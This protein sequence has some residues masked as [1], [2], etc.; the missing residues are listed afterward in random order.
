MAPQGR[1]LMATLAQ[2]SRTV[3]AETVS[4]RSKRLRE[5]A[6]TAV[7]TLLG[8]V[9]M[10]IFLMPLGYMLATAFKPDA[11][12]SA[13]H[14]PLWPAKAETYNYQNQDLPLYNVPTATGLQQWALVKGYREDSDF[15]D[16]AHPEKGVF[17]WKG[18]YRTLD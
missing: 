9:V 4:R 2:V 7:V 16:P 12:L 5:S 1:D 11:Q 18:R 8:V 17:N 10:L 14:A 6:L 15:I 13:Q 3:Q